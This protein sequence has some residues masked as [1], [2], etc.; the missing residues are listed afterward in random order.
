METK[1]YHWV[2]DTRLKH[3]QSCSKA[4][5]YTNILLAVLLM[6]W[7]IMGVSFTGLDFF[8][9]RT[10]HFD[11]SFAE[12]F[13]FVAVYFIIVL[14]MTFVGI[15]LGITLKPNKFM[16]GFYGIAMMFVIAIPMW[17]QNGAVG[18]AK[19]TNRVELALMCEY[20]GRMDW[21]RP[22]S[23][24]YNASRDEAVIR[25][26]V[27]KDA[28]PFLE[29][30]KKFDKQY[31]IMNE[32]MCSD[33]CPC[34]SP[35]DPYNDTNSNQYKFMASLNEHHLNQ[36]G[37]TKMPLKEGSQLKP[38]YWESTNRV[39]A[40]ESFEECIDKWAIKGATGTAKINMN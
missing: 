17:S 33:Q 21:T 11:Y 1:I 3:R 19:N 25:D 40:V 31:L 18:F 36:F 35:T 28:I 16:L 20:T 23:P 29:M 38:F 24:V 22:G 8:D 32:W 27:N 26:M 13:G 9:H 37:R 12:I 15:N 39:K 4:L 30:S 14:G 7:L 5:F 10:K 6:V 34:W 2:A